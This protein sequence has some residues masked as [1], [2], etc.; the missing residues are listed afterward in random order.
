MRILM[1]GWEFPPH[2]SG[3]LGTACY[4]ITKALTGLGHEVVFVVPRMKGKRDP[5]HVE[6]ISASEVPVPEQYLAED[7][8]FHGLDVRTIQSLLR[9][10]LNERQYADLL[11]DR[12][13]THLAWDK[14]QKEEKRGIRSHFQTFLITKVLIKKV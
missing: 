6:L 13:L 2:M 12:E 14:E 4:G 11:Q 1:F 8:V 7:Y 3:G 10:Y 9:P 5:S